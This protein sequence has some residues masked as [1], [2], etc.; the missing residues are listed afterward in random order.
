MSHDSPELSSL[1][2][3]SS[4]GSKHECASHCPASKAADSCVAASFAAKKE[5]SLEMPAQCRD[6]SDPPTNFDWDYGRAA[7]DQAHRPVTTDVEQTASF[8]EPEAAAA[9]GDVSDYSSYRVM[10]SQHLSSL[11]HPSQPLESEAGP[12]PVYG[13][14]R[15]NVGFRML[16][17]SGWKEGTGTS[18]ML[19][20]Y[21]GYPLPNPETEMKASRMLSSRVCT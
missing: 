5:M 14:P 12:Q 9:T 17:M 3:C 19:G 4:E 16:Q 10:V 8:P 1:Q 7:C 11:S 2:A 6:P 21:R 18:L 15:G 13:I 20:T